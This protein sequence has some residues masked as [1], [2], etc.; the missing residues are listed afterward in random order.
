MKKRYKIEF[1]IEDNC[2]NDEL[3]REEVIEVL[4]AFKE[5][6][7]ANISVSRVFGVEASNG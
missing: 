5:Y 7:M 4:D 6:E 3:V 1:E 2:I